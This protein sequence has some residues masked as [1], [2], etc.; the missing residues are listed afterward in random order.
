MVSWKN[1]DLIWYGKVARDIILIVF[2]F[3]LKHSGNSLKAFKKKSIMEF[4]LWRDHFG[5]CVEDGWR[6]EGKNKQK[7]EGQVR[8]LNEKRDVS[9]FK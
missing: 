3:Y 9:E 6:E 8:N 7:Q 5:Y 1:N 4:P 2:L